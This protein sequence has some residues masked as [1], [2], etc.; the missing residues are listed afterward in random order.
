MTDDDT[1]SLN[2]LKER[3]I[4][5]TGL[6]ASRERDLRFIA[7]AARLSLGQ[8]RLLQKKYMDSTHSK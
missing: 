2:P 5:A 1:E 3:D 6:I 7:R 8:V 4:L